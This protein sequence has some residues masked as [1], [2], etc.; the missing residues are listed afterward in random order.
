MVAI[1]E[2]CIECGETFLRGIYPQRKCERCS[3]RKKYY[4]IEKVKTKVKTKE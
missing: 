3:I 2:K 1:E 4:W